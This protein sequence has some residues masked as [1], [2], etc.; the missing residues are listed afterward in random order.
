MAE[1][2]EA[3]SRARW[4][5]RVL[6]WAGAHPLLCAAVFFL[7]AFALRLLCAS[8]VG[9]ISIHTRPDEIRFL[10]LAR[11]IAEGGPLLIQGAPATFQKLLYPLA[12]SPAFLL[13]RDPTAQIRLLVAINC[14][15]MASMM[16]PLALLVR[17]L[18]R[19]PAVLLCT[20]AA[21]C[22]LPDF[23][24]TATMMSESLYWP[25]CIWVFYFFH[26][27]IA[28]TERRKRLRLFTLFGFFAWLAYFTK[29]VGAA[30]II[31]AA[32]ILIYE[33]IRNKR[34]VQ[35]ALALLVTAAA[36]FVPFFI[37]KQALFPDMGNYY[38]NEWNLLDI[39]ALKSPEVFTFML[40]GAVLFF[41]AAILSFYILP[42]LLPLFGLRKMNAEKQR[43]FLFAVLSLALAAGAT[44]FVISIPEGLDHRVPRLH[45]RL[46]APIVVPF[47]ILC[48]DLLSARAKIM[49]KR[50]RRSA[51]ALT[52]AV[53]ILLP[54]LLP[55]VPTNNVWVDRASPAV[56]H[57]VWMLIS[58][59]MEA[60]R[61]NLL[62]KAWLACILALAIAG[63]ICFIRGKK[64]AVL[65][66]LLCVMLTAGAAE[67]LYHY[68]YIGMGAHVI[69]MQSQELRT[70][71]YMS[72]VLGALF[73]PAATR[74]PGHL[75]PAVIAVSDYLRQ[76]DDTPEN[77]V[78]VCLEPRTESVFETYASQRLRPHFFIAL[79]LEVLWRE[80]LRA[81]SFDDDSDSGGRRVNYIVVR[82]EFNP[83]ANTEIVYERAPFLVLRNPDPTC[84]LFTEP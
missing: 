72:Y 39:T 52:A 8:L 15:L 19:K 5:R 56:S 66:L 34:L 24:Y 3:R 62:W 84:V 10:H 73:P 55:S 14:L 1:P 2:P 30:F 32:A 64:K 58:C 69:D 74:D 27:A 25:L 75:A 77:Y 13:A 6:T 59:G 44:A 11:S 53:C 60:P 20:L 40:R 17:K 67:N 18:S 4:F 21:V 61:A 54:V 33:G 83:F 28:Q 70:G 36:F 46:L 51:L 47:M 26:C 42:V 65:A 48:F 9:P 79:H 78:L 7:L 50:G 68:R 63:A 45:L 76:V 29:E 82:E 41:A 38:D 23:M 81:F 22:V 43:M 57:L 12:V 31:A 71:R 35:N 49:K 16:F 80:G 37:V